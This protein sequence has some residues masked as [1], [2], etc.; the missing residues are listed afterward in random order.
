MTRMFALSSLLAQLWLALFAAAAPVTDD[1]VSTTSRDNAW[2]YGTSGGIIGVIVLILD[3]IVIVEV[4]Q[5]TR[6]PMSKLI[7]C[8]VVFLFPIVGMV[9]YWL[10]SNRTA[11]KRG[12]GYE[13]VS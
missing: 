9:I 4:L 5:S 8:L 13:P 3:L 2:E 6:S 11:H 1:M 10:F 12:A 7:W